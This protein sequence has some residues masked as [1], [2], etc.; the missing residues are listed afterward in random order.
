V[1]PAPDASTESSASN[2]AV[3]NGHRL[4]APSQRVTAPVLVRR[5]VALLPARW[6]RRRDDA[7]GGLREEHDR[8]A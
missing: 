2:A 4:A 3:N 1:A 7:N 8:P 5:I 6:L